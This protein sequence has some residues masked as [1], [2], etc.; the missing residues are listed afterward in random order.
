MQYMMQS[1]NDTVA[2]VRPEQLQDPPQDN[3]LSARDLAK[4]RKERKAKE[5]T[6]DE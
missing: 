6:Q 2:N 5:M 3:T 4:M 1:Q